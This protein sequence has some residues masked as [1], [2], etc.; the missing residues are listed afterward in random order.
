MKAQSTDTNTAL[1]YGRIPCTFNGGRSI[2]NKILKNIVKHFS[3][4]SKK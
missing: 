4:I 2:I 3:N 1:T